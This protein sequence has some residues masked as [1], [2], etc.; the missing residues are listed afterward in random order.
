MKAEMCK[1]GHVHDKHGVCTECLCDHWWPA[2]PAPEPQGV[3]PPEGIQYPDYGYDPDGNSPATV[4]TGWLI[5]DRKTIS[6]LYVP[7]W[8]NFGWTHDPAE[9]VRFCRREDAEQ[10]IKMIEEDDVIATEHQWG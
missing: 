2:T 6:W 7:E 8:S 5:E 10:V 3:R 4:E 9:A 1:C